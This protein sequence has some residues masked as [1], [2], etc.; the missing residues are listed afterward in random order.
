M[1][2]WSEI[3]LAVQDAVRQFVDTEIRPVRE[4]L[5]FGDL[6]PYDILRKLFKTFGIDVMATD[7]LERMLAK[8]GDGRARSA[9]DGGGVL[10]ASQQ[11]MAV[12]L[13]KEIARVSLGTV[14]AMGV[15]LGLGAATIMS[16]GTFA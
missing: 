7:A 9:G 6:P 5:E 15:S 13:T 3:E 14:A 4:E 1:I 11:G 16:R 12:I 8:E 10:G 2:Q